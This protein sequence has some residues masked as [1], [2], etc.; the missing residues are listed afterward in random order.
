MAAV[1][2]AEEPWCCPKNKKSL[3]PHGDNDVSG[4]EPDHAAPTWLNWDGPGQVA[5]RVPGSTL[6]EPERRAAWSGYR[7]QHD[8]VG[9]LGI[10]ARRLWRSRSLDG[11]VRRIS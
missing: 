2:R 10:A 5:A 9:P 3:V 1:G 4:T 11:N 6:E 8:A 7:T